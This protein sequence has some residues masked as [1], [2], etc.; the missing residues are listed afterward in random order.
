MIYKRV[1]ILFH[2]IFTHKKK[3]KAIAEAIEK[4]ALEKSVDFSFLAEAKKSVSELVE[5]K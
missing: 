5:V 1:Q 3:S 2:K 4:L